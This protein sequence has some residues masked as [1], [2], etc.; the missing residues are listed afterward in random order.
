[1]N[2]LSA[3]FPVALVKD[4]V[5]APVDKLIGLVIRLARET[6]GHG[7]FPGYEAIGR[8]ANVGSRSTVA[9]AM[10]ILRATRWLSRHT[11]TQKET[12][13]LDSSDYVLHDQP[14]PLA[15]ALRQ[16]PDYLGFLERICTH[17]H[18]RVR[19]VAQEVLDA[20]KEGPPVT[21]PIA[22]QPRVLPIHRLVSHL[23]AGFC[24]SRKTHRRLRHD[25][26][27]HPSGY[28][29]RV[30]NSNSA[31]QGVRISNSD[32]SSSCININTTTTTTGS[33][34]S[35][36][37]LAGEG[38][39]PLVYP[40]RLC[41]KQRAQADRCLSALA[42]ADRQAVL[43]ELE[44]RFQAEKQGMAPVFDEIRFLTALCQRVKAGTFQP[45]LGIKVQKNR[46]RRS[47]PDPTRPPPRIEPKGRTHDTPWQT[48]KTRAK[49]RIA[50]M[51]ARLGQRLTTDIQAVT[52]GT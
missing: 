8:L 33:A 9:R 35:N 47:A 49:A 21:S 4:P 23:R 46:R 41:A 19:A 6:D 43:D 44:G 25:L 38:D 39:P 42:P 34:S 14:L 1:M 50:E 5:L 28:N 37:G 40:A 22:V 30:R 45:N 11:P 12:D 18:A 48:R 7:A 3:A 20:I 51:R 16:D 24:F 26:I 52:C 27:Q 31:G 29:H 32:C 36:S 13:Q 10:A 2:N 17:G 15:D